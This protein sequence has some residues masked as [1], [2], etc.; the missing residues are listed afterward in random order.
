MAMSSPV[1][2][3]EGIGIGRHY[4]HI[5]CQSTRGRGSRLYRPTLQLAAEELDVVVELDI[6]NAL[7]VI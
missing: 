3:P 6:V 2:T 7:S 1:T 5:Q 4:R